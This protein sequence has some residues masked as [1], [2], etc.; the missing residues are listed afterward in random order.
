MDTL[1]DEIHQLAKTNYQGNLKEYESLMGKCVNKRDFRAAVYVF[2]KILQ[3][4]IVP[5]ETVYLTL[6][7]LHSKSLPESS[8]LE[9][10]SDGMSQRKLAPR[11]R[12]HKIIKGWRQKKTN[13]V[14]KQYLDKARIFLGENPQYKTLP[15]LS[16]ARKLEKACHIEFET[17]RRLVTKLKQTGYIT[18]NNQT[19]CKSTFDW[20]KC[21]DT[22]PNNTTGV[23][24]VV[25]SLATTPSFRTQGLRQSRLDNFFK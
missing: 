14:V 13:V 6:E 3:H 25:A 11:R 5:S 8:I 9:I 1:Q 12:I 19:D 21:Q 18:N 15:R 23:N 2:D 17:A 7:G 24:N 16:L 22:S 4:K 20:K 10:P